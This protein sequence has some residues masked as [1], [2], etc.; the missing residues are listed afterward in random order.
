M[1]KI[2]RENLLGRKPNVKFLLKDWTIFST[3]SSISTLSST[4]G[5]KRG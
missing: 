5:T 2:D 3:N 4:V 1:G